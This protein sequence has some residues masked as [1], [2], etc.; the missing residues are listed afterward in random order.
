MVQVPTGAGAAVQVTEGNVA[1]YEEMLDW[2]GN[3]VGCEM[4]TYD[5]MAHY[6]PEVARGGRFTTFTCSCCGYSP[7]EAEW[8][9][10]LAAFE[11]MSDEEQQK[12][13]RGEH[14]ETGTAEQQ[15]SRHFHLQLL[16][17]PPGV[18]NGM[19]SAGVDNLHLIFLNIF[20]IVFSCTIHGNLQ[21]AGIAHALP[22]VPSQERRRA[23]PRL[24]YAKGQELN[25]GAADSCKP[26]VK[27]YL[28]KQSFYSYDAAAEDESP[29]M[30][31]IGREVKRFLDESHI[32][33]PFLLRVAAAPPDMIEEM[34]EMLNGARAVWVGG[35][36]GGRR[37]GE[38]F[39][40]LT[41]PPLAQR[42]VSSSSR[43]TLSLTS[44][45]ASPP[46]RRRRSRRRRTSPT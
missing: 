11:K 3:T 13:A 35:G 23:P 6:S 12:V 14:N 18:R 38:A 33:L 30:R 24:D 45:S 1:T 43:R 21:G 9:K 7:K 34:E 25:V 28:K 29:V 17:M 46:R 39:A 2:I 10:D 44:P 5:Q 40:A 22:R 19:E 16:F 37:G 4:K 26:L 42:T 31:W 15:W 8:R 36:G 32:H 41:P 27:A 20:K